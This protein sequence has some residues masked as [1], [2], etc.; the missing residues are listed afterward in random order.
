MNL[1]VN[2]YLLFFFEQIKLKLILK[3]KIFKK[4]DWMFIK[5]GQ[6]NNQSITHKKEKRNESQ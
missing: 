4:F 1:K 6:P 3:F 5:M 2:F